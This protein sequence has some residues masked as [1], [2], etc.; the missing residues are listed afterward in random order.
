ML[1]LRVML[2]E[3]EEELTD[4]FLCSVQLLSALCMII[5]LINEVGLLFPSYR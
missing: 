2:S 1:S 4:T 3:D 5:H